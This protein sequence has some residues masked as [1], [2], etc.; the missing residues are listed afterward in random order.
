MSM[1]NAVLPVVHWRLVYYTLSKLARYVA[2]S[3]G[4]CHSPNVNIGVQTLLHA[5][6]HPL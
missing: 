3:R 4:A 1:S 5:D 6:P 2:K